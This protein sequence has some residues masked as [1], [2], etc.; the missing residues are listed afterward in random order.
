MPKRGEN[1]KAAAAY[2]L[3]ATR[4]RL[5]MT[6][7]QMADL[8]TSGQSSIA[9]WEAE[10]TLPLIYRNFLALYEQHV[11]G[12]AKKRRAVR[13]LKEKLKETHT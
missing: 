9:R 12:V 6:Q 2:D 7:K 4:E 10:G 11:H 13:E 8:L 3:K 1:L 5:S